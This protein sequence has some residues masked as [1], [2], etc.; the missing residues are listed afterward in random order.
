MSPAM[1]ALL[2]TADRLLAD[3]EAGP[4]SAATLERMAKKVAM[5]RA[6]I[7]AANLEHATDAAPSAEPK[8]PLREFRVTISFVDRVSYSHTE[9]VMAHDEDGAALAVK[10]MNEAGLLGWGEPDST[11]TEPYHFEV[12]GGDNGTVAWQED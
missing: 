10:A 9:T 12:S 8:A 2:D 6:A 7:T 5:M 3:M 1:K 11:D 4:W